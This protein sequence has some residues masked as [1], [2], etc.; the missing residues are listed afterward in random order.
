MSSP[1]AGFP[2]SRTS[3]R[4][5][6]VIFRAFFASGLKAEID[7]ASWPVPP[8][9]KYLAKLGKIDTDELLQSLNMGVGMILIVPPKK[10]PLRRSRPQEAPRKN[11]SSSA[12]SSAA[13]PAKPQPTPAPSIYSRKNLVAH[14]RVRVFLRLFCLSRSACHILQN[15][16]NHVRIPIENHDVRP[17]HARACIPWKRWQLALKFHRARLNALLQARRKRAR[18]FPVVSPALEAGSSALCQARRQIRFRD[19]NSIA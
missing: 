18:S 15:I 3:P 4:R 2:R 10:R 13:N 8:I 16:Y 14:P 17:D 1:A 7:L 11:S 5:I 12:A 6:P 19:S 9:F